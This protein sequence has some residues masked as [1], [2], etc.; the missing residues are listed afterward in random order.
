MFFCQFISTATGKSQRSIWFSFK[1]KKPGYVKTQTYSV[2]WHT[3]AQRW[4]TKD[5]YRL[6]DMTLYDTLFMK[7]MSCPTKRLN[8]FSRQ[9][10]IVKLNEFPAIWTWMWCPSVGTHLYTGFI[11]W[12]TWIWYHISELFNTTTCHGNPPFLKK[13]GVVPLRPFSGLVMESTPA[14]DVT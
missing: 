3:L 7:S 4:S 13:A 10:V 14:R 5:P 11:L 8:Y 2:L 6:S 9:V 1:A 12:A